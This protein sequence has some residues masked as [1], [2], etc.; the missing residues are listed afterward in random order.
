MK[1]VALLA[2]L[3]LPTPAFAQSDEALRLRWL[4]EAQRLEVLQEEYREAS[5]VQTRSLQALEAARSAVDA[6][7][8]DPA[9]DAARLRE[10][11][12]KL[13]DARDAALEEAESSAGVRQEIY[14]QIEMLERLGA[15]SG[16]DGTGVGEGERLV[17]DAGVA[18]TWRAEWDSSRD[19]GLVKLEANGNLVTGT[20]RLTNG[21]A[22]S[23][24]GTLAGT[25]L[26]LDVINASKGF[27]GSLVAQVDSS[28]NA[29][30]GTWMRLELAGS[31]RAVG[32]LRLTRLPQDAAARILEEMR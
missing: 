21:S 32:L 10:L 3:A 2:L 13:T 11:E 23:L 30:E 22:G 20:F 12:D 15:Q 16:G 17:P 5:E 26:R 24:T 27:Q 4:S 1:V 14:D 29:I 8:A 25:E 6:A 19:F 9:V 28:G 7:L 18:G 31:Q